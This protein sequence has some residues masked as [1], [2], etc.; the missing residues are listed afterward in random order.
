M[1]L[2]EVPELLHSGL[3]FLLPLFARRG[4]EPE[5]SGPC[6]LFLSVSVGHVLCGCVVHACA[7]SGVGMKVC[8]CGECCAALLCAVWCPVFCSQGPGAALPSL[9]GA[10]VFASRWLP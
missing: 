6:H 7:C 10:G 8:T 2:P 4:E 1:F 5:P 9:E 3:R